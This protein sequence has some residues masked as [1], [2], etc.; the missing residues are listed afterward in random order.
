M[1]YFNE[2][3]YLYC[4]RLKSRIEAS[5][6]VYNKM[7]GWSEAEI[8]STASAGRF[9]S[10]GSHLGF[11]RV[12]YTKDPGTALPLSW[13]FSGSSSRKSNWSYRTG[14]WVGEKISQL[15]KFRKISCVYKG[16]ATVGFYVDDTLISSKSLS[17]SL[18]TVRVSFWLPP[19]TKGRSASVRVVA[20]DASTKIEEIGVWVGEQRGPMP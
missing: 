15:K 20:T 13:V 10:I 17:F 5:L 6:Y 11:G 9:G 2:D 18:K 8:I 3:V 14:D 4:D 19:S 1:Y 16:S 7:K 12:I